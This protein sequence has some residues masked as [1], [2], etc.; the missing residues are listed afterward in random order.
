MVTYVGTINDIQERREVM[1]LTDPLEV[2]WILDT[3]H[4]M[5]HILTNFPVYFVSIQDS[6][7]IEMFALEGSVP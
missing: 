5:T 6:V 3:L 2:K 1:L 7:Y 4:R